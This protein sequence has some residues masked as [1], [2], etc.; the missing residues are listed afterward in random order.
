VNNP[1]LLLAARL[2]AGG[3]LALSG[4]LKAAAPK[5]EFAVIIENYHI[6]E[7]QGAVMALAGLLPWA[8][9]LAGIALIYGV[10]TRLAAAA[11]GALYL[12]FIVAISSS[13]AR[14]IGLENCGCFGMGWHLDPK[15]TLAMD[16]VLLAACVLL[17]FAKEHS[18]SLDKWAGRG[19]T[20]KR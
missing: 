20:A 17:F 1:W 7:S 8:E 4:V 2:L 9:A 5:E 11:C 19:Y 18:L 3:V 6:I 16:L 14:K 10:F 15:Q 13:L 12:A